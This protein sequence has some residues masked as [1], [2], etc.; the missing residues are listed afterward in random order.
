MKMPHSTYQVDIAGQYMGG[1]HEP[2]PRSLMFPD[3]Y[4]ARREAG[5]PVSADNYSFMKNSL[6]QP[7]NQKWLDDI[8]FY[9]EGGE[10]GY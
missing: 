8:M 2:L 3:W 7:T 10:P 4:T 1:L 6:R 5:L 9:L